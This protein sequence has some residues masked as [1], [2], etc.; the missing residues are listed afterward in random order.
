MLK[1]QNTDAH[2]RPKGIVKIKEK[3]DEPW[4]N[5]S[6]GHRKKI[7]YQNHNQC[8][9]SGVWQSNTLTTGLINFPYHEFILI[10][11]GSLICI[12]DRGVAHSFKPAEALFIPQGTACSWQVKDKVSIYYVQIKSP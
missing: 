5:T 7:L 1:G 4:Q 12:D 2:L 10:H 9:T 3:S 8:F 6:D 11:S